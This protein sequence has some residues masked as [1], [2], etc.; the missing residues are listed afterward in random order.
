MTSTSSRSLPVAMALL[1]VLSSGMSVAAQGGWRSAIT[2]VS[3]TSRSNMTAFLERVEERKD[4]G[5]HC[6]DVEIDGA[7]IWGIF[8]RCS[9]I[10]DSEVRAYQLSWYGSVRGDDWHQIDSELTG[11]SSDGPWFCQVHIQTEEIDGDGYFGRSDKTDF[12]DRIGEAEDSGY[13]VTD[14]GYMDGKWRALT[15]KET[16]VFH[17]DGVL[18]GRTS[19][20]DL[21]NRTADLNAVD[22]RVL[23]IEYIGGRWYL[24]ARKSDDL[25]ASGLYSRNNFSDFSAR[26]QELKAD[27]KFLVDMEI[28]DGKFYGLVVNNG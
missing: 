17:G 14:F 25:G 19:F 11:Y 1:G 26:T 10:T 3:I 9:A 8:A 22:K 23:D 27:G 2:N 4:D 28:V 6:I 7:T 24:Y 18:D 5:Y 13:T 16:G 15:S 21:S 12:K 20:S